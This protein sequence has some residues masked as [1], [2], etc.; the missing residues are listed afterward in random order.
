MYE[1]VLQIKRRTLGKDHP[2]TRSTVSALAGMMNQNNQREQNLIDQIDDQTTDPDLGG[3]HVTT[4][5]TVCALAMLY[6]NMGRLDEA[7]VKFD[8][9]PPFF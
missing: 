7:R 1:R 8:Q 4:L 9:V 2:S 6:Y 5:Q 3:A